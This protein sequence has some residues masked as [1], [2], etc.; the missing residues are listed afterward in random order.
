MQ[1]MFVILNLFA[2]QFDL[3]SELFKTH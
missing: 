3:V 2:S 1:K